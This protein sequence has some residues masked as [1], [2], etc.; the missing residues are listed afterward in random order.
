MAAAF[1]G[2]CIDCS[3]AAA[4]LWRA[5]AIPAALVFQCGLYG[6]AAGVDAGN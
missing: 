6:R 5:R 3:V 1:M 2:Q 4:T